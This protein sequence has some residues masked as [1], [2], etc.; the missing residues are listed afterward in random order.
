MPINYDAILTVEQKQEL[1]KTRIEQFA[2]DAYN[3]EL[4]KVIQQ[5]LNNDDAVQNI[6]QRINDLEVA[7]NVH[8]TELNSL[9]V[10]NDTPES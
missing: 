2:Y 4:G 1:L 6:E 7:I 5:N 9:G 3:L 8:E 10:S